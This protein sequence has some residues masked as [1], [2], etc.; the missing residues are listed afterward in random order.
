MNKRILTDKE[1]NNLLMVLTRHH[2]RVVAGCD[3][4][5][6]VFKDY[7]KQINVTNISFYI[8]NDIF[9]KDKVYL[10]PHHTDFDGDIMTEIHVN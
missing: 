1:K 9:E 8:N 3:D 6:E 2:I 5:I 4:V 7:C 10:L